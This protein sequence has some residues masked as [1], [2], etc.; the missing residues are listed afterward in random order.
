MPIFE[1]LIFLLA[2]LF[3]FIWALIINPPSAWIGR[4]KQNGDQSKPVR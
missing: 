3:I 4:K 2:V 1:I